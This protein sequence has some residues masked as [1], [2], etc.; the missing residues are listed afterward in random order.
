MA[1]LGVSPKTVHALRA[2]KPPPGLFAGDLEGIRRTRCT[3]ALASNAQLVIEQRLDEFKGTG[4]RAALRCD[5]TIIQR[6]IHCL[7]PPEN[8]EAIRAHI[9]PRGQETHLE[10]LTRFLAALVTICHGR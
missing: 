10:C 5:L 1:L 4:A 9:L 2:Y 3:R 6:N 7:L 8:F